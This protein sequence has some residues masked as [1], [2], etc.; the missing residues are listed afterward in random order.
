MAGGDAADFERA[1]PLFEAMGQLVLHAGPLGDGQTIKLI[2]NATA[3]ANTVTAAQALL[4]GSAAGI[5]LDALEAVMNAG[6]G[7]S[8]VL[9]LKA[10]AMRAHDWTTLFKLAHMLKD[11]R[12]CLEAAKSAG[13]EFA[14]AA[15]AEA[16]LAAADAQGLGD[17]DF[18]ALLEVLESA[19]GRRL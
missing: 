11:V 15:D 2:N 16:V 5:D 10:G 13:V 9:A 1:K 6:S 18:A 8:A 4:V 14:A 3:A 7:G 17:K 12:L 19:A